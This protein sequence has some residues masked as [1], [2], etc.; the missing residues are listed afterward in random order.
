MEAPGAQDVHEDEV[1]LNVL[2]TC[3]TSS[4]TTDTLRL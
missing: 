1:V 3:L 2:E 4:S